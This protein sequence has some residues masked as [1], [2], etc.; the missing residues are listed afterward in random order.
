MGK[1]RRLFPFVCEFFNNF[2]SYTP[3]PIKS[4]MWKQCSSHPLS[5]SIYR[6]DTCNN[7]TKLCLQCFNEGHS[8]HTIFIS[9]SESE[10]NPLID[11]A[12]DD[13]TKG[14]DSVDG[15]DSDVS[16]IE[17][18]TATSMLGSSDIGNTMPATGTI[19]LACNGHELSLFGG[20]N[21]IKVTSLEK[22]VTVDKGYCLDKVAVRDDFVY[23]ASDGDVSSSTLDAYSTNSGTFASEG[24]DS[25]DY[26]DGKINT[27]GETAVL[28]VKTSVAV[29]MIKAAQVSESPNGITTVETTTTV[30]T[31]H[32]TMH[33]SG[34]RDS[35]SRLKRKLVE[36]GSDS[37][38]S[39]DYIGF[40]KT[41]VMGG[42]KV[43]KTGTG[44]GDMNQKIRP[45]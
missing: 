13:Q 26:S 16:S 11:L 29:D 12:E 10:N 6:C 37:S 19:S 34:V 33:P 32:E 31:L 30:G 24:C 42:D 45:V 20:T 14:Q 27:R 8:G 3:E 44:W 25:V 23:D 38:S 9:D 39:N 22:P 1:V 5:W 35:S 15:Y 43:V 17:A 41:V 21:A 7:G 28:P 4:A 40:P 18:E 36:S 2:T